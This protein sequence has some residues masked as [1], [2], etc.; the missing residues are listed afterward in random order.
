[1]Q[2]AFFQR[3][4]VD[5][6]VGFFYPSIRLPVR[7]SHFLGRSIT[8]SF[9]KEIRNNLAQM[10]VMIRQCVMRNNW[11]P[12]TKVVFKGQHCLFEGICRVRS[13]TFLSM[14]RFWKCLAQ[15]FTIMRQCKKHEKNVYLFTISGYRRKNKGKYDLIL[16]RQLTIIIHI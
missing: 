3:K 7:P 1:L 15:M 5:I 11:T 13:L 4:Q 12:T 2:P 8:M 10:F 14:K 9:I 6:E 16:M